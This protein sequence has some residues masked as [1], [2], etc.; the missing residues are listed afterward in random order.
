MYKL[1]KVRKERAWGRLPMRPIYAELLC[2]MMDD[3]VMGWLLLEAPIAR[4][5]AKGAHA[6][7]L[8][9]VIRQAARRTVDWLETNDPLFGPTVG[10]LFDLV[11]SW[12]PKAERA[13][14]SRVTNFPLDMLALYAELRDIAEAVVR[15]EASWDQDDA[16]SAPA[17]DIAAAGMENA[18]ARRCGYGR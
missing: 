16:G 15:G 17:R 9:Q 13:F 6:H 1:P 2:G 8:R 11:E 12:P 10:L 18:G 4:S 14:W 3:P 7:G 5:N